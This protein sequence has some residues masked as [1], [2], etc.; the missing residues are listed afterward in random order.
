MKDQEFIWTEACEEAFRTLKSKLLTEAEPAQPNWAERFILHLDNS[1]VAIGAVLSQIIEGTER[2]ISLMSRALTPT[3]KR[4]SPAEGEALAVVWG[5]SSFRPYPYG[6]EST[7]R[8][9]GSAITWL[10]KQFNPAPSSLD[11]SSMMWC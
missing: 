6:R 3:E 5:I 9:D 1:G 7:L 11:G 8:N 2:P 4:Y 10:K